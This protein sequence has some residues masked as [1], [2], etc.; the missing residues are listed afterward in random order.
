MAVNCKFGNLFYIKQIYS[1]RQQVFLF[2]VSFFGVVDLF[3]DKFKLFTAAFF[4]CAVETGL[5][6]DVTLAGI[7]GYFEEEAI[8][9]TINEYLLYFLGMSAFFAFFP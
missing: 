4:Q 7:D 3:C 8:L 2:F 5:V 6:A 1:C 9:V